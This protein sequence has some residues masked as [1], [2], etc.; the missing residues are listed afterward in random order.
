MKRL[1]GLLYL[2]K[3]GMELHQRFKEQVLKLGESRFQQTEFNELALELFQ[4][5]AAENRVYKAYLRHLNISPNKVKQLEQIPFLPIEFFKTQKVISG[6]VTEKIVF[7]SSGTTSQQPSRHY[8][9]DPDFYLTLSQQI[10]EQYYGPLSNYHL[11]A[12]LPSYLERTGSSLIYMIEHFIQ[13]SQ[14]AFSGFY[15]HNISEL[16]EQLN[17]AESWSSQKKILLWGVTFGMLDLVEVLNTPLQIDNLTVM[18]TGGMKG[19]RKELLRE[20][21]HAILTKGL[22]VPS[23][24]SEYGMTELLS[25]GYS[26]GGGIFDVPPTMGVM[27]RE[28]NDPLAT[29]NQAEVRGGINVIDLGNVDSCCF[30]ETK[31]LGML[32]PQSS[33]F[34]V[35]GRFDNADVRGCNLMVG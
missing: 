1:D 9:A 26:A 21:V 6:K 17:S 29:T 12:L 4:Y 20:E 14:S 3:L 24:H 5:Q 18:E 33:Q 35:L 13:Q 23:I 30:I 34:K 22:S 27:V 25:Q 32:L 31:D 16:I 28:V 7:E 15:L 11:L 8:V 10:F 2:K 19:R